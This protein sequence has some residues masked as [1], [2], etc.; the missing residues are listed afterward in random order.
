MSLN[1]RAAKRDANEGPIVERLEAYRFMVGRVSMKGWPDLV[2]LRFEATVWGEVKQP[3]ESFTPEQVE[4]FTAMRRK[5]VDVYVFETVEDVDR[6]A[7]MELPPWTGVG[8]TVRDAKRVHKGKRPHRPGKDR[9]R[10][11]KEMCSVDFCPKSR[12][13]GDTKC[14]EH[15][16]VVPPP[17][18]RG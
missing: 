1:R 15:A 16:D 17:R 7:K 11:T 12:L 13:P 4:T 18:K 2:L 10:S 14:Q 6:F 9:M 8:I 3:G 5:G